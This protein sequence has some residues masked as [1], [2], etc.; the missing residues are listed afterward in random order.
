MR[1]EICKI[2]DIPPTGSLIAPFFGLEVHVW[3]SGERIRAA[4]NTCLHFGGPLDCKDGAFVCQWHGA[5]FD[6]ESGDRLE[7]P[8]PKGSR[9]MF[10]STRVE[11]GVLNYV[12][13]E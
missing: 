7:G 6:M 10:L 3:R 1:H 8:A 11:D 9:L 13:G 12:W 2:A 4:A 5:R